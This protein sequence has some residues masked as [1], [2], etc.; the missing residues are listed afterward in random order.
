MVLSDKTPPQAQQQAIT[1]KI[2]NIQYHSTEDGPGIRTSIFMKG[3]PMH[4]P[5]CHN[6]EGIRM[7][8]ELIWYD[9]RC[10][11]AKDC[12]AACPVAALALTPDGIVINREKCTLCGDCETACPANALEIVGKSYTVEEIVSKALQDKVFYKRSG[13]G[14][15]F[16]GGEVSLQA[17]FVLAA[18]QLLKK[19]GIHLAVDTCGGVSWEKLRPLVEKVDLVL[20][21]LKSMD[22]SGHQEKTGVPLELVLKNAE[23][24]SRM[25]KPMWIRTPVIPH[26]NDTEE[27]IRKTARFI[28]ASLPSV[29]RYDILAFN[30]TCSIKYQRLGLNWQYAEDVLLSEEKMIHLATTAEDE[31]LDFVHWSG[32]T[33][34]K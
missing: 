26:F 4:C 2:F 17:D 31:G 32:L 8:S 25:G 10:I 20:Y 19:E 9:V 21:D 13:G 27:N 14:V 6:P 23:N 24:I 1:G 7:T 15:T 16:S 12:I 3:C 18:M 29:E 11:G 33:K 22:P 34:N 30:N 5:W 28:K